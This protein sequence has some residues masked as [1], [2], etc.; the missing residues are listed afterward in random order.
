MSS[1]KPPIG[2]SLADQFPAVSAQ[3]HPTKNGR[4]RPSD[5]SPDSTIEVWW[6]CP[7]IAS[8]EWRASPKNRTAKR[9]PQGCRKCAYIRR[10]KKRSTP[11]PGESLQDKFPEIAVEWHPTENG[12]LKPSDVRWGS[13]KFVWW[14][15]PSKPYHEWR[16]STNSRTNN[17]IR[18]VRR[19][20]PGHGCPF[21]A[22]RKVHVRDSL[23]TTRPD[24]AN[25]WHPSKNK[26]LTP[27][28][29]L[30]N[31]H[32]KAFW[33]CPRF[34]EHVYPAIIKNRARRGDTCPL[35]SKQTSAPEI[36]LFCEIRH[37]FPKAR[38]RHRLGA[39]EVDVFI[40][41]LSLGIEYD[42]VFYHQHRHAADANK[43]S[44]LSANGISLIRLRE[45]GLSA[46]APTDVLRTT[47]GELN[48]ADLDSVVAVIQRFDKT[49]QAKHALDAY[50]ALSSFIDDSGY[51]KYLSYLP[52][53]VP[54][55]SLSHTHPQI[56]KEFDL[57]ANFPLTPSNFTS[58]SNRRVS[59]RCVT[60]GHRWK[61]SVANRVGTKKKLPTGCPPCAL[62]RNGDRCAQATAGES[63]TNRYPAIASE[64]HPTKNG[65]T[66]ASDVKPSSNRVAWWLCSVCNRTTW[67]ASPNKRTR[68]KDDTLLGCP[69]CAQ[70]RATRKRATARKG[71]SLADKYP[72]IAA[73][74]HPT[75][76]ADLTPEQV[77]PRS[78]KKRWWLCSK[79]HSYDMKPGD[80][81]GKQASGCPYCSGTRLTADRSLAAMFP[82]IA[83]EWHPTKN[84]K[85]TPEDI[86]YGSGKLV[87]WKC[88]LNS[89]HPAWQASPNR[90]TQPYTRA[91]KTLV[92]STEG[93]CPRCKNGK[94]I[95]PN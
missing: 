40:E 23:G 75:R 22:G 17:R 12:S 60:C 92:K 10:G 76:N 27:F 45:L 56:A 55:K 78:Q 83:T 43:N 94:V 47:A 44:Q 9:S 54:E 59:W 89:R 26:K 41:E 52:N 90:R 13:G 46:I 71:E 53:P 91:K 15:C 49:D 8:H 66:S 79:G 74:W 30:P 28:A 67:R 6:T 69:T 63:L 84:G 32:R 1:P 65:R 19:G 37:L 86:A 5:V 3:W 61:T 33:Q 57:T 4:L 21:C 7:A 68:W 58:H 39:V 25:E 93:G 95:C 82:Q 14:R 62:K 38:W 77:F 88:L 2:G 18:S 42:G 51:R 70:T 20:K 11:K 31:S 64:W 81:T 24:L 48:K 73:E 85:L 87:W 34:P 80:R 16:A 50:L 35:C 36:R 72:H 29:V